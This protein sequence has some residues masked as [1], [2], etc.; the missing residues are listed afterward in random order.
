[1]QIAIASQE[2]DSRNPPRTAGTECCYVVM[3][4]RDD[5][6]ILLSRDGDRFGIPLI[7]VPCRQRVP[8]NLLSAIRERFGFSAICRFSLPV[9]DI[10]PKGRCVVLEVP[11]D[12]PVHAHAAWIEARG[13]DWNRI[14]PDAARDLLWRA[15]ARTTA[16]NAG[17]I[18]GRFVRPGWLVEV[19]SWVRSSL[20][21]HRLEL[22]GTWSQYNMGP[23]YSLIR[24]A[25][26]RGDVWFKAVGSA[27]LRE[28]RITRRLAE[29]RLPHLAPLLAAREDWSAWLMRGC[30]GRFLDGG[31]TRKDWEVAARGLAELEVASISHAKTLVEAGCRD[32]RTSAL[33]SAVESFLGLVSEL[34][35]HQPVTPPRRLT[36]ADLRLTEKW[37]RVGCR[38]LNGFGIPDTLGHSD[39][40]PGNV[41]SGDD[42]PVFL[43]WTE[44]HVAHPLFSLEYLLALCCRMMPGD[45]T[46]ATA[47][48]REYLS[49]WQSF[50]A[51]SGMARSFEF[52]PL[53]APLAYALSCQERQDGTE[54]VRPEVGALLRSIARRMHREAQRLETRPR[55]A[56]KRSMAGNIPFAAAPRAAAGGPTV[57]DP[58]GSGSEIAG[59][60]R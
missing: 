6:E 17:Q 58:E 28:F 29:L 56:E 54:F 55:A 45:E 39:L 35:G 51:G 11:D 43:D 50:G 14:E 46:M 47:V 3:L 7:E 16:Y 32:L 1:M 20:T 26:D 27:N 4:R 49:C 33:E 10:D 48:R 22:S 9:S 60:R 18:T 12:E 57:S 42:H 52:I 31:A 34:M 24:F 2:T 59:E 25:A 8:P 53:L 5:S 44:G 40:N 19:L 41:L 13:I 37:V 21:C 36:L 30:G 38:E 15:L 23:D